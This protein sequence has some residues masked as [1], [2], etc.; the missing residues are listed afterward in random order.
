MILRDG[1]GLHSEGGS[2]WY[3]CTWDIGFREIYPHSDHFDLDH[4]DFY[5][6]DAANFA[7]GGLRDGKSIGELADYSNSWR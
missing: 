6:N 1:S 7:W 3:P 4:Y 5:K 2:E